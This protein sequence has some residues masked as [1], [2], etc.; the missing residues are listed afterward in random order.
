MLNVRWR[1]CI[2]ASIFPLFFLLAACTYHLSQS[3][4][5]AQPQ[6]IK[7]AFSS[8]SPPPA[9]H[10]ILPHPT[11]APT[12]TPTISEPTRPKYLLNAVL[13][14]NQ[15][16]LAVEEQITYTNQTGEALK[17]IGLVVEPN[18]YAGV[19]KLNSLKV[20]D[21]QTIP[22]FT[23]DGN[24]LRLPLTQ[25]LANDQQ[26]VLHLSY[27]LFLP[28]PIPNPYTRP[29][30][31][32]YTSRQTNLVDWYPF[33]PPYVPGQGWLVHK[34]GYFGEHLVYEMA[35]FQV[36][37]QLSGKNSAPP[38][39]NLTA[40]ALTIA[41]SAPGTLDGDY[42]RFHIENARNFTWSVSNEY[43]VKSKIVGDVT[44]YSYAFRYHEAAG[45]A[46]L[47]TTAAALALYS[48]LFA[49]YPHDTLSVVEADFLDG[50]E[51]DGLYF[52][53]NGFYNLYGGAP[54]EYLVDIAAHETAHQWWYALVGNDQAQEPWLDEA[55]CTYSERLFY[56]NVYPE[57][58][59]WWWAYRIKYYQP[60][61]WIDGSI[62]SYN[63]VSDAYR[64]YRDAVYL[65]GAMFLE[66]LRKEIGDEAFFT[67]LK[68]YAQQ[69]AGKIANR[70]AFFTLLKKHS[71]SDLTALISQYFKNP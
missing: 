61:G 30:P 51:F 69:N 20:E 35:D 5:E 49:P 3:V 1:I 28:S 71:Q 59:D 43:L 56:E 9:T 29:V 48:E 32:G 12:S 34:P 38:N 46:A 18:R 36:N 7:P 65:N 60:Q 53:S 52:L 62:Y 42:I 68:D 10:D 45:E 21:G 39:S 31:F 6:P 11:L 47:D 4:G 54:G 17:E 64:A 13:D 58:L 22:A 26:L 37:I 16:H 27:E 33:I 50:M 24:E 15:H 40:P 2:S 23:L 41:A 19:F 67:F 44:I 14:Y 66:E 57:A 70:Q 63:Y 25:P 8:P 55:L